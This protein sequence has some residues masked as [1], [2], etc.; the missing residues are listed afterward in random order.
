MPNLPERFA[1]WVRDGQVDTG[2][3]VRKLPKT[4]RRREA[5]RLLELNGFDAAEE[6]F[7]VDPKAPDGFWVHS[8]VGDDPSV[9]RQHIRGLLANVARGADIITGVNTN[10]N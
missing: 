10:E 4:S 3:R 6:G 7:K 2:M 9:C 1:R 8:F 5:L